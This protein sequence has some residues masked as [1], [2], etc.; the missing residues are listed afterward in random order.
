MAAQQQ[1][2]VT[3]YLTLGHA[4]VRLLLRLSAS[5]PGLPGGRLHIRVEERQQ[6]QGQGGRAG[7]DKC[8]KMTK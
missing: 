4:P 2:G 7:V 5:L 6:A 3:V 8:G 1:R